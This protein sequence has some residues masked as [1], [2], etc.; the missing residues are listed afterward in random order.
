L[1][2]LNLIVFAELTIDFV[3]HFFTIIII[4]DILNK[5]LLIRSL[6]GDFF[7]VVITKA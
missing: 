4:S 5:I 7:L 6:L 1:F 2:H 3:Q